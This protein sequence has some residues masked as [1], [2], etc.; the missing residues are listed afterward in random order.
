MLIF[1][2]RYDV[3]RMWVCE[4]V[5]L[6]AKVIKSNGNKSCT[7]LA[8]LGMYECATAV[9]LGLLPCIGWSL[10]AQNWKRTTSHHRSYREPWHHLT[11]SIKHWNGFLGENSGISFAT[12]S[13]RLIKI[14]HSSYRT[15]H[16]THRVLARRCTIIQP[17]LHLSIIP[18]TIRTQQPDMFMFNAHC[19]LFGVLWCVPNFTE[20]I[21]F[22]M[23]A[24]KFNTC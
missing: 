16:R 13:F 3:G 15:R 17:T 2:F 19:V 18:F 23:P 22:T 24:H 5:V 10:Q 4:C 12:A 7:V 1:R 9:V 14:L 6:P 21:N 20:F 8:Q 11:K